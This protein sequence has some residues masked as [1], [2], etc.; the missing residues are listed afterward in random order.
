MKEYMLLIRNQIDHQDLWD[1]KKH[2]AF[3]KS[4]ET[5]IEGLKQ[6]KKLISAQPM[7]REGNLLSGTKENWNV[8]PFNKSKDVI[9]G[10]Y[11]ILA[12]NAED[13]L[14]TAKG[15]PEFEFSTTASVEIRP[16]KMK[17]ASTGFKYPNHVKA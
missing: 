8:A 13:A 10:Y 5:Y 6:K 1:S 3:L 15:N 12:N 11:H 4:C 2:E 7:I 14:E 16:L 17:E 9:V